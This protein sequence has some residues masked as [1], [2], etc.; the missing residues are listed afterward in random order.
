MP[1]VI[2][3]M[4]TDRLARIPGFIAD[5]YLDTSKFPGFSLL[6]S[7]GGEITHESHQ[8]YSD[9]AIFRIYSMSKPITSVA[10]LSLYEQGLFQLDDPVSDFIPS[11]AGLEVFVDGTP[12][13]YLTKPCERPM[14]VRDLLSHTAGLTYSWMHRH[15]VDAMYRRKGVDRLAGNTLEAMCDSLAELPLLFSPGTEW[16]YSVATDVCG[17]LVE[18]IGG[19]PLD[20][21]FAQN[22]FEALG[23]TDTSFWVDEDKA[24]RFTSNYTVPSL[25]PFGVPDGA[26]GDDMVM[27]DDGSPGTG[28][29]SKPVFL[30]GGGG[31][32]STLDD[33]HRFCSMLLNG[34]EFNGERILGRKT[35][36]Y[37]TRNHLGSGGDLASMGQPVFSETNYEGT[38]F[39][40]GFSVVMDAARSAVIGSE[41][42]YAWGGA[43][44][45]LFWIDPAEE[46]I[47]IGLTQL[48]PSS[49]YPIRQE[50]KPQ[51]Y[52][53][54]VD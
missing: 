9:D 49:A 2:A 28:Y 4:D 23:M 34:G 27:F 17:R 54:L 31:L 26:E 15:P 52:G 42:S 5:R 21:F 14:Q 24:D 40:L 37:A 18:I 51:I 12:A 45:T 8:N 36:E 53:A 16:S 48:M 38:G 41:G 47:V 7:R 1:N 32:V 11:W 10:L 35:I 50:L 13:N 30:S 39:G 44:S 20:E 3:G 33:Y 46:L 19:K 25:S 22:I 43:A 29:R 6:V